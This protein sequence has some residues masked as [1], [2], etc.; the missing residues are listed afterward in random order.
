MCVLLSVLFTS[1]KAMTKRELLAAVTVLDN[2]NDDV[3]GRTP[4]QQYRILRV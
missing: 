3:T 2:I 1:S 4:T